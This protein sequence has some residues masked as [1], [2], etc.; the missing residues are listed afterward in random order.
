MP[1]FTVSTMHSRRD[2]TTATHISEPMLILRGKYQRK[3]CWDNSDKVAFIDTVMK[4]WT[5]APIYIIEEKKADHVFD[6]AHK[7]ETVSDFISDKFKIEK[8]PTVNWEKSPLT[9]YLGKTFSEFDEKDQRMIRGYTF[10]VNII[11]EATANDAQ[12]LEVL[13]NRLNNSGKRLNNFESSIPLYHDLNDIVTGLSEQWCQTRFFLRKSVARGRIEE[14]LMTL[15]ALSEPEVPVTFSSF[16]NIY[17]RWRL[18]KFGRDVDKI[19]KAINDH[20]IEIT[21]RIEYMFKIYKSFETHGLFKKKVDQNMLTAMIAR[22]AYWCPTPQ[23]FHRCEAAVIEYARATFESDMCK[24]LE[25]YNRNAAYQ[26]KMIDLINRNIQDKVCEK[27]DRRLFT[28]TEKATKLAEQ[29]G[30]CASCKREIS[31]EEPF[32]GDHIVKWINGGPT[33]MGN[34]QVLCKSCH[35]RK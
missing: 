5:C 34:L 28:P 1:R 24:T 8:V 10:D 6:G 17:E 21:R 26:R 27:M 25:C 16:P 29:E 30:K 22:T 31:L 12:E 13:W 19:Q 11:D 20:R 15:L 3:S 33:D 35:M 7:L 2:A 23:K 4:S 9:K 18:A 14:F 32:E